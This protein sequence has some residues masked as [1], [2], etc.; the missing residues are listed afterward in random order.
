MSR[1]LPILLLLVVACQ[2]DPLPSRSLFRDQVKDAGTDA[3]LGDAAD[4]D[5]SAG[6]DADAVDAADVAQPDTAAGDADA[7]ANDVETASNDVETASNDVETA[8]D[9]VETASSD[10]ETASK[11]L[12]ENNS[13][14]HDVATIQCRGLMV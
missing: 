11:G 3:K 6:A 9:D 4:A 7:A 5:A 2:G 12:S 1:C 13:I 14:D 8:S 10:V